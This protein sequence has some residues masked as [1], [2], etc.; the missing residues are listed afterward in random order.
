VL[1]NMQK[2]G[3]EQVSVTW[4]MADPDYSAAELVSKCG[5]LLMDYRLELMELSCK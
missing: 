1:Y 4:E 5:G 3:Y 2:R